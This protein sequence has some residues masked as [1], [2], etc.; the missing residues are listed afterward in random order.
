MRSPESDHVDHPTIA[1]ASETVRRAFVCAAEAVASSGKEDIFQVLVQGASR[2][3]GVDLA[4]IGVLADGR[5]DMIRTIAVCDGGQIQPDFEYALKGTPCEHVVGQR[6]RYH[7]EGIQELFPD[8]H[9]KAIGGVGYAAI[10]LFDSQGLSTGLMAL[11][12]RK[13]LRDRVLSECILRIFSVRAAVELERR[14]SEDRLRATVD[15]ALDCIIAMDEQGRII[16]L[17]PA[18]ERTFGY[19]K[20]DALGRSLAELIIPERFR[21][22]HNAGMRR[23]LESGEGPYLH[24]QVEVTAMRADGTEFSAE[25]AVDVTEGADGRFFIGYLRDITA[26]KRAEAERVRLESQLRQ[27]QKMEAIGQLTGGIAH[28]FNNILTSTMGY[29]AM[30]QERTKG[31]GD[32]K[33]AKYLE[34]AE[35]SARRAKELIQQMLTFSRGQRGE[36]R[37]LQLRPQ[38]AEM[39]NLMQSSLPSTV[40]I[41]TDFAPAVPHVLVDPLHVEQ[42]LM[43]LC[44]NAKDAMQGKGTLKISLGTANCSNCVC[45]SCHQR[46]E[47]SFVELA[48]TDAGPG[49]APEVIERMFEPFFSTKDVGKGSGMGLAM[50]HGLVHEYGGHIR[51]DTAA[52]NG[53]T[54]RLWFPVWVPAA[55]HE[56]EN[57]RA[58]GRDAP[59]DAGPATLRGRVLLADDEPALREFMKDLLE[60]WGLTVTLVEN[61]REAVERFATAPD[62]FDIIVLDQTM[63]RM[64]GMEAA[65]QL[66]KCHP[67]ASVI[68]YTGHSEHLTEER[69]AAAGIRA[70]VRKPLDVPAFRRMLEE[71]LAGR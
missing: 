8:P 60:S 33:L 35:R 43:N 64:T 7:A 58:S 26:R 62:D 57:G 24:R 32:D 6:F 23:F 27:A 61:G 4:F 39:V 13:P 36:P 51:V 45:T 20:H 29:L 11:I 37:P 52:G 21:D 50:V 63:P 19:T 59:V 46:V 18:A 71:L 16:E 67:D 44:I 17:N 9:V 1:D 14:R 15:L 65:E 56:G 31:N 42:A 28:D 47:G 40:E 48:V 30:A 2:A 25:L 3:L 10:P 12:D 53:T 66:L 54:L 55:A 38:V 22:A 34:R 68:L 70:L 69:V 5:T 49:I 41:E